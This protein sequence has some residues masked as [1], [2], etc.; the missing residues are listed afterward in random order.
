MNTI[1]VS[2][3][4]DDGDEIDV[5]FPAT[6]EVCHRC[7]G[8]GTH[9]TPSIGQ[10]AFSSEEFYESFSEPEDR[11]EY[12]RRGGIYDVVC[13]KCHGQNVVLVID[14]DTIL[15]QGTEEQKR[16]LK[17]YN[18]WVEESEVSAAEDRATMRAE[19]GYYE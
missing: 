9:L 3:F 6:N 16:Q 14:D 2:Y 15:K 5:V 18:D 17:E 13:E 1:E 12:F 8:F 11:E 19:N 10:H 4:N 7:E